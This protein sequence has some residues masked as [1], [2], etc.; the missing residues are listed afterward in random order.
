MVYKNFQGRLG[1]QM[2][3]YASTLGILKANNIDEDIYCCFKDVY[4]QNFTNDLKEFNL[5]RYKEVED[6]NLSANQKLILSYIKLKESILKKKYK[7]ENEFELNRRKFE[8]R[9]A[10]KFSRYGVLRLVDGY[11][12]F[13][14]ENNNKKIFISGGLESPKY[15]NHIKDVILK[16][17]T[18]KHEKISA[19][20]FLYEKIENSNSVCISV[21]RGDFLAKEYI[22]KHYV[23][24]EE[25]FRNAIDI[26]NSKISN[27]QF[28][29]FSDDIDWCKEAFKNIDGALFECGKDPVW[30][31]IRLMYSCKHFI[32]SNST[33]SWWSQYLSRN[34]KKIV[35]APKKWK[36]IGNNEDIYE[37][38]WIK[39]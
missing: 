2:F 17:F 36:N 3:Q 35:I 10:D 21:R 11:H 30:E 28:I 9:E 15:F 7:D 24:N 37:E 32:I 5:S 13:K 38:S 4:K 27:P 12:Y 31:K 29:F 20:T 33:F 25:Y 1:N 16:E 26:M 18:P 34:P 19:N 8:E 23:C 14:V 39:I 22:D 6:I